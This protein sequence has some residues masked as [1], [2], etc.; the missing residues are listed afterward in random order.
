ML[1]CAE[2]NKEDYKRYIYEHLDRYLDTD[3][4]YLLSKGVDL[5]SGNLISNKSIAFHLEYLDDYLLKDGEYALVMDEK[6][7]IVEEYFERLPEDKQQRYLNDYL[8]LE[9]GKYSWEDVTWDVKVRNMG[10]S[11]CDIYIKVFIKDVAEG[12]F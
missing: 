11:K 4:D 9:R 5:F 12:V 3:V 8:L 10:K 2:M 7:E 1:G 6:V